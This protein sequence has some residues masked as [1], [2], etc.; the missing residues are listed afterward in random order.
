MILLLWEISTDGATITNTDSLVIPNTQ[1]VKIEGL[2]GNRIAM[3]RQPVSGNLEL[4]V[5][6][7]S[8]ASLPAKAAQAAAMG[9]PTTLF[10]LAAISG[11][12]FVSAALTAANKLK[13]TVWDF[14][15]AD[16]KVTP[17]VRGDSHDTGDQATEIAVSRTPEGD[18]QFSV[19][20]RTAG[21]ELRVYFFD[22]NDAGIG[23]TA[24][25]T[26]D[27]QVSHVSLMRFKGGVAT[28]VRTAAGKACVIGWVLV[29]A[30]KVRRAFTVNDIVGDITAVALTPVTAPGV[31]ATAAV[32]LRTATGLFRLVIC[33][34][35]GPNQLHLLC[36]NEL[37]YYAHLQRGTLS[38]K[39]TPGAVVKK[40]DLLARAGSSGQSDEPHL[41]MA[42]VKL[43]IE[44]LTNGLENL[45][46]KVKQVI[47]DKFVAGQVADRRR[48]LPFHGV[49][50]MAN[51]GLKPGGVHENPFGPVQNQG[52]GVRDYVI[53][54]GVQT[55][56]DVL[57]A[58]VRAKEAQL[59]DERGLN[60]SGKPTPRF[61]QLAREL[62]EL[63]DQA[64]SAGCA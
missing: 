10:D 56:C 57:T 22:L 24:R 4:S 27:Q 35:A 36:G 11:T 33:P 30:N 62:Q 52:F 26:L 60:D 49:R 55:L 44:S 54:P 12:R 64:K 18:T 50:A 14:T 23:L 42:A 51:A 31:S 6:D 43:D 61:V 16:G 37:V 63:R 32:G 8:G 58:R 1:A 59:E 17:L 34:L 40:G 25:V 48:G 41:H 21:G 45:D 19:A 39:L 2:G 3:A 13:A 28:A 9:G 29:S 38:K 46:P 20:T 7:V 53:Y 15:V 5:W 47:I